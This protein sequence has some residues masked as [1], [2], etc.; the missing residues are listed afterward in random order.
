MLC[1]NCQKRNANVHITQIINNNKIEKYLC[2][3][4]ANEKGK[5]GFGS[6][7]NLSDFLSGFIVSS[8]NETK[9]DIEPKGSTCEI[10]GMNFEDFRKTGKMG[11]GSCYQS[12]GDK[13]KPILK[14]LH[15][16]SEH[17]GKA[18]AAVSKGLEFSR[19]IEKLKELLG[20]AIQT[21]EYEKAA[22]IR[23]RIKE[24]EGGLR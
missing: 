21:E 18:P 20:K 24:M 3:Q 5:F 12:Y 19:E 8:N 10:C 23:D 17:V 15:G 14:R 2:D 13:M 1:Q 11:C 16:N 4:C 7:I 22:E 9:M 6:S